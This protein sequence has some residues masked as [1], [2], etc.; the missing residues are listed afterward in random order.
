MGL[1]TDVTFLLPKSTFLFKI[2]TVSKLK[3]EFDR[4]L[5]E[6]IVELF[7]KTNRSKKAANMSMKSRDYSVFHEVAKKYAQE[8]PVDQALDP[9]A[10]QVGQSVYDTSDKE[11]VVLKSDQNEQKVLV[12]KEQL[13]QGGVPGDVQTVDESELQTNYQL[14]PGGA[15]KA[16]GASVIREFRKVGQSEEDWNDLLSE[17][18]DFVAQVRRQNTDEVLEQLDRLNGM[19]MAQFGLADFA[20]EGMGKL[21]KTGR[22]KMLGEFVK[23]GSS[24][25][26][27][28]TDSLR[29]I[30]QEIAKLEGGM[31]HIFEEVLPG[32]ED[33]LGDEANECHDLLYDIKKNLRD[34]DSK[35][36]SIQHAHMFTR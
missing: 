11:F 6:E 1:H 36:G 26:D 14:Q 15:Q 32:Q 4:H 9:N 31:H 8:T 29:N 13:Q 22:K 24:Y 30:D 19:V 23:K 21:F 12:P 5:N 16:V 35:L 25:E 2:P 28:I 34:L 20:P 3:S 17:A 18:I 10:L 7:S 33:Y 27:V